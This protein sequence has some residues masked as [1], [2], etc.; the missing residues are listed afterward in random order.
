MPVAGS[1]LVGAL[2]GFGVMAASA[3]GE[4]LANHLTGSALPSYA[5]A[6]SL[7]RYQDPEYQKL[8]ATWDNTG[9][10]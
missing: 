4:L 3:S 7:D 1:Y 8:L 9:Q 6:F 5:P 2:S 10:I